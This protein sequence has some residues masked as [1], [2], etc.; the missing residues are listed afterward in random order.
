MCGVCALPAG[1]SGE[2]GPV[3]D[4]GNGFVHQRI[5]LDERQRL[6]WKLN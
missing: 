6:V 1:G 2:A 3:V 4:G 5:R